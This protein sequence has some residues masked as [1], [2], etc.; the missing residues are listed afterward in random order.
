[1]SPLL[2]SL[3]HNLDHS[4]SECHGCL[5]PGGSDPH[6]LFGPETRLAPVTCRLSSADPSNTQKY[7][8]LFPVTEKEEADDEGKFKL[9]HLLSKTEGLDKSGERRLELLRE[10]K[11][12][13]DAGELSDK[14]EVERRSGVIEVAS[15]GDEAAEA[16]IEEESEK[17][18]ADD[19]FDSD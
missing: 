16:E 5:A 8:S 7:I 13:M 12:L 1:M 6:Q 18:E 14:P 19:F 9:P 15:K 10:T 4:P 3:V 2:V 11:R 17:E